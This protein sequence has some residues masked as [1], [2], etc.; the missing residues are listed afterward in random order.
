MRKTVKAGRAKNF[1]TFINN[2]LAKSIQMTTPLGKSL[3]TDTENWTD[4][5]S[6]STI[7]HL[8]QATGLGHND[9]NH[10]PISSSNISIDVPRYGCNIDCHTG[11]KPQGPI[12][13]TIPESNRANN[14]VIFNSVSKTSDIYYRV[15]LWHDTIKS[16]S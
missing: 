2:L 12:V 5:T 15:F 11:M 4:P 13:T 1:L 16:E 9:R 3:R 14:Y 10:L 8:N 6:Q 7:F